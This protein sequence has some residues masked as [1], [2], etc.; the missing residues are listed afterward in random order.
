MP[1]S[2]IEFHHEI[3]NEQ[4]ILINVGRVELVFVSVQ[5]GKPCRCPENVRNKLQKYF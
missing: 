4:G 5:T 2:R 3:F 1:A